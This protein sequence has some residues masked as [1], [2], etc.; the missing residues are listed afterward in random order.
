MAKESAF[1]ASGNYR[2]Y[3]MK[4]EAIAKSKDH[5]RLKEWVDRLQSDDSIRVQRASAVC[6]S[7]SDISPTLFAPHVKILLNVLEKNVHPSGSRFAFRVLADLQIEPELQGEVIDR[8]FQ[9]L[10]QATTPV[11]I[12]VFAMTVIA[13]HLRQYPELKNEFVAILQ[14]DFNGASAGYKSRAGS[15]A[16]KYGLRINEFA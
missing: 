1:G 8:A 2:D 10:T 9:F 3:K 16:K 4:G 11:A 12:K 7:A 6:H 14:K 5:D 13:N 15:I